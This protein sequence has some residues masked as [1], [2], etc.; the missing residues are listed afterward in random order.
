MYQGT[1]LQW[2]H[3]VLVVDIDGGLG[4]V[5]AYNFMLDIYKLWVGM[6]GADAHITWDI[7]K[8]EKKE[9]SNEG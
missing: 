6:K 1:I 7:E 9:V 8:I 2:G 3:P 5:E 4:K